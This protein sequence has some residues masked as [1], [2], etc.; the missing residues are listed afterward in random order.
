MHI[1]L[2][3]P[4]FGGSHRVFAEGLAHHSSHSFEMLTLPD[5][6]WDWRMRGSAMHIAKI[7]N[8]LLQKG[9]TFDGILV[10]NMIRLADLKALVNH[11]LPPVIVYFHESQLTYPTPPGGKR[12]RGLVISDI[13][14]A[15]SADHI[16]FNSSYH[17]S[18]FINSLEEWLGT[19]PDFSIPWVKDEIASKSSVIYPGLNFP[20][21]VELIPWSREKTLIIWNHKN[22][23][24]PFFTPARGIFWEK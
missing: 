18:A 9:K 16:I 19:T 2:I 13:T 20:D 3:E 11:P 7:L 10:S 17:R 12:D 1:L 14:T 8:N 6:N 15:L 4:F 5:C 23:M 24:T 22:I 21:K